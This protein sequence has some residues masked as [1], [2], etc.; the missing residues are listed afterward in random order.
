MRTLSIL[1]LFTFVLVGC[2]KS[3]GGGADYSDVDIL[4]YWDGKVRFEGKD[5]NV[6]VNIPNQKDYKFYVGG[7]LDDDGTYIRSGN[8][9]TLTSNGNK[10]VV[11]TA[12]LTGQNTARVVLNKNSAYPGTYECTR[13]TQK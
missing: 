8:S 4:G 2:N 13:R 7:Y 9:I 11:G 3:T 6:S 12:T 5:Y 10:K 1:L